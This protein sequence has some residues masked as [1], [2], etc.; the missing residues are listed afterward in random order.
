MRYT[1]DRLFLHD[2]PN[3]HND[4]FFSLQWNRTKMLAVL[5]IIII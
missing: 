1:S 2:F 3:I 5:N 4:F